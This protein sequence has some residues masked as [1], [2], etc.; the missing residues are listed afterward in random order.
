LFT[1]LCK[2]I[3]SQYNESGGK[4][5]FASTVILI[6]WLEK[7]TFLKKKHDIISFPLFNMSFVSIAGCKIFTSTAFVRYPSF[8]LQA[9]NCNQILK[10]PIMV[11]WFS[12]HINPGFLI[13]MRKAYN[14]Y[15]FLIP[16][17]L[18]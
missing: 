7:T 16:D 14:R 5:V 9:A 6:Q 1:G 18:Y 13:L 11:F 3:L 10:V 4:Y 17:Y 12:Y 15:P 8:L 2:S